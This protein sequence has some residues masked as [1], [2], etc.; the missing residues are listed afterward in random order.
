MKKEKGINKKTKRRIRVKKNNPIILII[1]LLVVVFLAPRL[2]STAK[3]VYN[4]IHEHYLASQDFYF[5]SDKL[6]INKTTYEFTNNW[7]GAQTCPIPVNMSSKKN[8]LAYTKADITYTITILGC[9]SNIT[10]TASKATGIIEGTDEHSGS[11]V[12]KDYFIVNINPSGAAL[13]EGATAWV[14]VRAKSTAPYE[15][16]LEGRLVVEVSSADI[17]YEIVDAVNQPYL[18][19]NVTNSQNVGDDVTLSYSPSV[20]LLDMTDEF[21]INN[22]NKTTQQVGSYAYL[23]SITSHVDLLSTTSVK[24]YKVDATQNYSYSSTSGSGTP[25]ITL[26]H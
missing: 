9:S 22:T 26:T 20:V 17:S 5:S 3:Y 8:D 16:I 1:I 4:V 18:T 15:Q 12:N 10:A 13:S 19:V 6:N 23:N 21:Y 11:G 24:F 7:S 25:V 14:D 2:V